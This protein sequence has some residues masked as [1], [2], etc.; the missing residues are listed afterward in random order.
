MSKYI[1]K[2][3]QLVLPV[4]PLRGLVVFP[5]IPTSFEISNARSIAAL[6]AA[7]SSDNRVF[8]SLLEDVENEQ[9]RL[10][11]MGVY[12]RVK[13]AMKLPDGNYR[14]L[15][16]ARR[17]GEYTEIIEGKDYLRA[18]VLTKKIIITD[19]GGLRG[20]ALR[21][22]MIASFEEHMR[23]IPKLS[24]D[25]LVSVQAITDPGMLADY[26]A[27]NLLFDFRNKQKVLETVDP[28]E[29]LELV[30]MLLRQEGEVIDIK[31]ELHEKVRERING[32]QRDYFLREQLKVIHE[33]LGDAPGADPEDEE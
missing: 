6:E 10:C 22:E 14:V 1:E 28:F 20:Q 32:N 24:P 4:I 5:G 18:T 25:I 9:V 26:V 17:R 16:E 8:L 30:S 31:N 21:A 7:V 12:A 27:A 2:V 29:R 13:Q 3:E 23:K 33:E 15:V 19:N 11:P